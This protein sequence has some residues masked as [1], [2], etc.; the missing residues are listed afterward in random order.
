MKFYLVWLIAVAQVV[1]Q[2]PKPEPSASCYNGYAI[3]QQVDPNKT[4]PPLEQQAKMMKPGRGVQRGPNWNY[5]DEDGGLGSVGDVMDQDTGSQYLFWVHWSN[6]NERIYAM[7]GVGTYDLMLSQDELNSINDCWDTEGNM[8]AEGDQ[9]GDINSRNCAQ[10]TCR[11]G[12]FHDCICANNDSSELY[13]KCCVL[14][15]QLYP[16]G[17]YNDFCAPLQCTTTPDKEGGFWFWQGVINDNCRKCTSYMDPH[18]KTFDDDKQGGLHGRHSYGFQGCSEYSMAQQGV[19][20]SP[21]FGVFSRFTEYCGH[22]V[23]CV[24]ATIMQQENIQVI[25]ESPPH[26]DQVFVTVNGIDYNV[27]VLPEFVP[28][29]GNDIVLAWN[30]D[31]NNDYIFG[32]VTESNCV[33]FQGTKGLLIQFCGSAWANTL[34]IWAMPSLYGEIHG[35]CGFLNN[36]AS[37]DYTTRQGTTLAHSSSSIT[38]WATSWLTDSS[39]SISCSSFEEKTYAGTKESCKD[40]DVYETQCNDTIS[41]FGSNLPAQEIQDLIE[42][43]VFDMCNVDDPDG[44]LEGAVAETVKIQDGLEKVSVNITSPDGCGRDLESIGGECFKIIP[45]LTTDWESARSLCLAEG[46]YLAEPWDMKAVAIYLTENYDDNY[47]WM[48]AQG[49]G[50]VPRWLSGGEVSIAEPWMQFNYEIASDPDRCMDIV[51]YGNWPARGETLAAGSCDGT[52]AR[53]AL[54]SLTR[55]PAQ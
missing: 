5:G 35:L 24:S 25:A 36:D 21:E 15:G 34:Y 28:V 19:S 26:D 43:C 44:Y 55:R 14:E 49:D 51:T 33:F 42:S 47:Y 7:Q 10:T 17:R 41:S 40:F 9:C 50:E 32:G 46:L 23:S 3:C 29:D 54:C 18:V 38:E 6:G 52:Q 31:F 37:D 12:Y 39:A 1:S 48:G 27:P 8:C 11:D 22:S 45:T 20:Y 4:P 2:D 30:L 13:S 16:N 53:A